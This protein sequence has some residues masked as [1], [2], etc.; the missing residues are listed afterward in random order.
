MAELHYRDGGTW[1]KARELH[2]RDGGT[3]RKLKEAWYRDAGV[4][5]KVFSGGGPVSL[6]DGTVEYDRSAGA[7]VASVTFNTNG[8]VTDS[9]V[10]DRSVGMDVG[11]RWH[12]PVE[13]FVGNGYWIRADGGAWQQL[14]VDRA[15]SISRAIPGFSTVTHFFEIAASDGGAVLASGTV[16]LQVDR[17]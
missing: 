12:D 16:D 7:A 6:F 8:T 17:F 3:W 4:W 10:S 5:R 14:V 9:G 13:A 1:R 2:Y 11:A 15:W